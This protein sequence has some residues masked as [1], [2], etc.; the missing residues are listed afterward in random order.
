MLTFA[1]CLCKS[2]RQYGTIEDH[3]KDMV[4]NSEKKACQKIASK[5]PPKIS[6]QKLQVKSLKKNIKVQEPT[7]IKSQQVTIW[8]CSR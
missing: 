5:I 2:G 1:K 3:L 8:P 4:K 6:T 7:Q